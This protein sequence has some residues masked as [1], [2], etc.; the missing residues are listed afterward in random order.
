M[1]GGVSTRTRSG[2]FILELGAKE[3]FLQEVLGAQADTWALRWVGGQTRWSYDV[4]VLGEE[5]R[6]LRHLP[7]C[8]VKWMMLRATGGFWVKSGEDGNYEHP[9]FLLFKRSRDVYMT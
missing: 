8:L 6:L 7:S 4:F 9:A 1:T 5:E 3:P 2:R